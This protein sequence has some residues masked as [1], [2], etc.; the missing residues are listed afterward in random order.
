MSTLKESLTCRRTAGLP[1]EGRCHSTDA[2]APALSIHTESGELWVLPWSHFV[3]ARLIAGGNGE[4][5]MLLFANHEVE[6]NGVRLASLVPE[7]AGFR[8]DSLRSLPAKYEPQGDAT[9]PFIEH[10]SIR[11]VGAPPSAENAPSS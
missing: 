8:L 5:L 2:S 10:L 6:L 3:S 9:E 1:S 4:R 7:I 11:P